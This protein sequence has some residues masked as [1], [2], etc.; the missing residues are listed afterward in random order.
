MKRETTV[1]TRVWTRIGLIF[2]T[3]T[4]FWVALHL[5]EVQTLAQ[6]TS[7]IAQAGTKVGDLYLLAGTIGGTASGGRVSGHFIQ[8]RLRSKAE[9]GKGDRAAITGIGHKR[10]NGGRSF[11][12]SRRHAR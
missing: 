1:A 7:A 2:G 3:V 6:G 11:R 4:L 10:G 5:G 12:G 8:R 9:I